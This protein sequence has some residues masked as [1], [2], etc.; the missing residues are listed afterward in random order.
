MKGKLVIGG[1]VLTLVLGAAPMAPASTLPTDPLPS[2]VAGVDSG[3][4]QT[5]AAG[6]GALQLNLDAPMD[7]FTGGTTGGAVT[8][9]TDTKTTSGAYSNASRQSTQPLQGGSSGGSSGGSIGGSSSS[10]GPLASGGDLPSRHSRDNAMRG[11]QHRAR[12]RTGSKAGTH[13][14][15]GHAAARARR[16]LAESR[17]REAYRY[18]SS[19]SGAAGNGGWAHHWALEDQEGFWSLTQCG[20]YVRHGG[21]SDDA[22]RHVRTLPAAVTEPPLVAGWPWVV[23]SGLLIT[24]GVAMSR[25][26][27]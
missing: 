22:P 4:S 20:C 10:S 16:I 2:L 3:I 17:S 25:R 12:H 14:R 13:A 18:Q 6:T 7:V 9:R 26:D 8:Q 24:A 1:S 5:T 21:K 23:L 19:A 11:S 27:D 15:N